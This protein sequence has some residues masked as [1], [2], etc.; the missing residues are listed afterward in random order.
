MPHAN[1]C[2]AC[3]AEFE[4]QVPVVR[5]L[6]INEGIA[7]SRRDWKLM[8]SRQWSDIKHRSMGHDEGRRSSKSYQGS[9][10]QGFAKQRRRFPTSAEAEL[11]RILTGLNGGV[12]RGRFIREWAFDGKWILD[13]FFQGVRLGIEVDGSSHKLPA[14]MILD[15][16]KELAC[17]NLDITLIRIT[18]REVFGNRDALINRLR[19]GWKRASL[20]QKQRKQESMKEV[21]KQPQSRGWY[22]DIKQQY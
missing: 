22:L 14:Q 12:L 9:I 3:Q 17:V 1:R 19:N 6:Q 18:N 13:F 7:G 21:V 15:R 2:T 8:R 11:D 10:T 5:Q 20:A 16:M 4:Q